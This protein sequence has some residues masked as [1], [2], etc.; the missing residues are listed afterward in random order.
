MFTPAT[1]PEGAATEL[2]TQLG[3]L[4]RD[5]GLPDLAVRLADL[6]RWMRSELRDFERELATLPRGARAVQRS[7]HH[8]LDLGGKHLRPM[9]VALAA[10]VGGG[11]DAPARQLA[12]AV[13]LIHTAT[14]LHDDVVDLGDKRRGADAARLVYGNAASI[15]A[16]DWLLIE[17]LRRVRTSG[18]D[19]LM[20]RVLA[21]IEEM[22]LAESLQLERRGSLDTTIEDYFRV[23]EG[24]TAALFRWAMF[25]GGRAGGLEDAECAA[26]ERY[27]SHLGVAF[28]LVD[29]C[30]DFGGDSEVT[31]K[32]LHADLRE[33]KM[34]YPLLLAM[35]RDPEVGPALSRIVA[36]DP[37]QPVPAVLTAP[38]TRALH[39]T[40]ALRECRDLALAHARD[41]IASLAPVPAGRGADALVTVAEATVYRER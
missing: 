2:I 6:D 21:I 41:A 17:A 36:L 9:C 4:C 25:A 26:L 14:L 32:S 33:G 20:D 29:D 28:Q 16:G 34:T 27:G 38:I 13:E 18:I 7:A 15:F 8:L 19:D 24:K 10:K 1:A 30:L 22:I 3:D 40:G 39:A 35:Q 23:V 5:R 11:F 37:D 31:G 12:V